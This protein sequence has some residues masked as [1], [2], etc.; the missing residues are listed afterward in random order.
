MLATCLVNSFGDV[1]SS[2]NEK[3]SY[4]FTFNEP[5][6][7][8]SKSEKET[9]DRQTVE[10]I[11]ITI[12]GGRDEDYRGYTAKENVWEGQWKV[13]VITTEELVI[14][15]IHFDIVLGESRADRRVETMRF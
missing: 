3:G 4:F 6:K 14:G 13:D 5:K 7:A 15:V 1:I 8:T 9:D 11:S 2:F 12:N 10:D